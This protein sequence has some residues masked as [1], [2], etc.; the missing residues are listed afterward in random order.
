MHLSCWREILDSD[1][2]VTVNAGSCERRT[3]NVELW[4]CVQ[5]HVN[6]T[7]YLVVPDFTYLPFTGIF[8]WFPCRCSVWRMMTIGSHMLK[9]IPGIGATG[10]RGGISAPVGLVSVK[11]NKAPVFQA[12]LGTVRLDKKPLEAPTIAREKS[13]L[14]LRILLSQQMGPTSS[15]Y[16]FDK[17]AMKH[18]LLNSC[19][20]HRET[21]WRREFSWV[22]F[23][24]CVFA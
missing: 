17:C 10:T 9:G 3:S 12:N 16:K 24:S 8:Q 19:L 18:E 22:C 1:L 6:Y 23:W 7:L 5:V 11:C 21:W 13:S 15:S 2:R 20:P 14:L 4:L